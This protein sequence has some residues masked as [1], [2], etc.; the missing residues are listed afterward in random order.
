VIRF[1]IQAPMGGAELAA[2]LPEIPLEVE[3]D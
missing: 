2:P 1:E 3:L